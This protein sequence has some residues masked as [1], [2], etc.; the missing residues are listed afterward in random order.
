MITIHRIKLTQ[1]ICTLLIFLM[2]TSL[3]YAYP[4]DN[5]AVLYY[6]ACLIYDANN[7]MTKKVSDLVKG[8]IGIDKEIKEYIKK[9][10]SEH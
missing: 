9:D 2:S 4:P 1:S 8:N 7:T 5:A 3:V 10:I 6:R